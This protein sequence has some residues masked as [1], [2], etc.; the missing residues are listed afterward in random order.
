MTL[1]NHFSGEPAP[2]AWDPYRPSAKQPWNVRRVVHLHRR[3]GF[4]ATWTQ[5]QRDLA[6]GPEASVAR[7]LA[8][9]SR[10]ED[11]FEARA[12]QIADA[13]VAAEDIARLQAWWIYRMLF[14]PDPLGER[15]ALMWHCHFATSYA[16]VRDVELMRSQNE[17]H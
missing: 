11:P 3:A 10:A 12:N 8:G 16:K 15:L 7:L 5:I 2:S 9:E 13:A 17:A 6:D 14:S 1:S 4:A